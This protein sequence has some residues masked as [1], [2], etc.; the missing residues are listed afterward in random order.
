MSQ[1]LHA[2]LV[3]YF[4]RLQKL[5]E[6]WKELSA[7]AERPLEAL[8]NQAEQFRHVANVNINE[9]E[10][11][12]DGETR[13]RLMFKILMGLEDEIALLQDILTQF[14]D[15]NQDLKN[16]L[17]KLEN[18]RSQVSLKDETMQEL[19]KGTSYRP[20]LNLLLEWAVESFQFY[21]NMYLRIRDCMKSIDYKM[22][23]TI[24]NLIS[25]FVEEQRGRRNIYKILAFTQFLAKEALR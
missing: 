6:K 23:E 19:I 7:K 16:Y 13:E 10:N 22:E 24:D 8:A 2:C 5:D 18:A 21:H 4:A 9:T 12:M 15:A 20:K 25:S 3:R 17:I 14:N 1:E 11:D